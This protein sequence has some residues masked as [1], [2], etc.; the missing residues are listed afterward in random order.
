MLFWVIKNV[1]LTGNLRRFNKA[2]FQPALSLG[3][4]EKFW[5]QPYGRKK[6]AGRKIL[7]VI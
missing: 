5:S 6:M 7:S 3:V 2:V 4:R 1:I